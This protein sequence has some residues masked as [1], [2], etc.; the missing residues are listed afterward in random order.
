MLTRH[1]R[2]PID[3]MVPKRLVE[4]ASMSDIQLDNIMAAYQLNTSNS[5]YYGDVMRG[6]GFNNY[7]FESSPIEFQHNLISL[8]V[9]LGAHNVAEYLRSGLNNRS[10]VNR[11]RW[12]NWD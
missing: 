3:F 1:D 12:S 2:H 4:F 11:P 6:P 8:F 10:R 5:H 7:R 9:F